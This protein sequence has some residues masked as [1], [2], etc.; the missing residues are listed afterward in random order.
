MFLPKATTNAVMDHFEGN[1]DFKRLSK[2]LQDG[3]Q[4]RDQEALQL[5]QG[6]YPMGSSTFA[7]TVPLVLRVSLGG[8]RELGEGQPVRHP[9]GAPPNKAVQSSRRSGRPTVA[10]TQQRVTP[11]HTWVLFQVE[12]SGKDPD[13]VA[14]KILSHIRGE[15]GLKAMEPIEGVAWGQT[16]THGRNSGCFPH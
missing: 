8:C 15:L 7:E 11:S 1:E 3:I 2:F 9:E 10:P 6:S 4:K 5:L 16:P 13:E 14:E 12:V